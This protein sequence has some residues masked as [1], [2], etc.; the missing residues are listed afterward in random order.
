M[1]ALLQQHG[2]GLGGAAPV[3][4]HKTVGLVP[5][6]HVFD[7]LD[8]HHISHGARVQQ[9]FHLFIKGGVA[10][11]VAHNHP[12]A[13]LAGDAGQQ[14]AF[15]QAGRHRLFQQQVIA[16]LQRGHGLG[17]VLPVHGGD[18]RGVRQ[19]GPGQQ[20]LPGLEALLRGK[21]QQLCRL[22]ALFVH[23]LGNGGDAHP[24]AE[25]QKFRQIGVLAPIAQADQRGG[26]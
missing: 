4:P 3:A 10:Q 8:G 18:D 7:G 25:F 21:A 24:V 2:A 11:H 12:A 5:V 13:G 17:H 16:L 9:L 26:E 19:P 23:R 6:A 22:D 15:L 20:L 1:A 14:A